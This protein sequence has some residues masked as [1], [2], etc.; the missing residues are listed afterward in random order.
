MQS[1]SVGRDEMRINRARQMCRAAVYVV[2]LAGGVAHAAAD[3]PALKNL[4]QAGVAHGYPGLAMLV[5][6]PDGR[7]RGAAAG[8]ASI[9]EKRPLRVDDAFNLASVTKTF[10]AISALRLVDQG[11]LSLDAKLP[12]VL[13]RSVVGCMPYSSQ[14]SVRQLLDHSSGLYPTNNDPK[15]LATIVGAKADPHRV[16]TG[17]EMAALVCDPAAK[18]ADKPGGGHHYSDTNYTLLGLIVAR[19]SGRPYKQY[20]AETIFKPLGMAHTY[21]YSD[22]LGTGATNGGQVTQGYMLYADDIRKVIAISPIF[23]KVPGTRLTNTTL[24]GERIDSVA[25]IVTTLPDLMQ[26][27]HALFTGKLLSRESQRFLMSAADG[28]EQLP[29]GKHRTFALQ[30]MRKPYGVL[31]YKEGDGPGGVNTLMAYRPATGTIYVGFINSF[32][33]FDEVDFMMDDVIGTLDSH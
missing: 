20:V 29:I 8:Y 25:G 19:V 10:T 3:D 17:E 7:L 2:A 5:R 32:G 30:A 33:Y 6:E 21:F 27:A 24:A 13:P 15:Y 26:Y 31:V 1:A 4:L 14:I 23:K 22:R 28:M 16:W 9:E 11:K 12:D 18:P